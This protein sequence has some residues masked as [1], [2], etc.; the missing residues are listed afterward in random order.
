MISILGCGPAGLLAAHAAALTG[1]DF[2]IYSKKQKSRIGGA[3]FLHVQIPGIT[4][5]QPDTYLDFIHIGTK[6]GY[7]MKVYGDPE[8]DV[9]WGSYPDGYHPAWNMRAAYDRLWD[10]YEDVIDDQEVTPSFVHDALAGGDFIISSIPPMAYCIR[11]DHHF[12][13]SQRVW[14][15]QGATTPDNSVMYNGAPDAKWYRA[16]CIFE[17]A[18]TEWPFIQAGSVE[19]NKPLHTNCDCWPGIK[20]V[21]R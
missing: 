15:T 18:S 2:I 4:L 6:R 21:G 8:A 5:E 3:Q 17:H 9:S 10:L 14:I 20:R 1:Q 19:V 16:S 11:P 12:F 13:R 7:A